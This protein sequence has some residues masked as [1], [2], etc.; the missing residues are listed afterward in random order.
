MDFIEWVTGS[1]Q[2]E[3]SLKARVDR[4]ESI[5]KH[6][7]ERLEFAISLLEAINDRTKPKPR[8]KP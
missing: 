4:L 7:A 1:K 3:P 8:K 5:G 6:L 2:K